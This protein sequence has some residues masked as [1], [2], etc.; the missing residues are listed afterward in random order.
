M[1]VLDFD[2]LQDKDTQMWR[3]EKVLPDYVATVV[4]CIVQID[5]TTSH[6]IHK[7]SMHPVEQ[8]TLMTYR[9]L[10]IGRM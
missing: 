9:N 2:R 8:C 4:A 3:C 7:T 6:E 10:G 1:V 5:R